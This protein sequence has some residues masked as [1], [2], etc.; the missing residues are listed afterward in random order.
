MTCNFLF[1][2][3]DKT[4][5]IVL[6]PKQHR[7]KLTTDIATLDGFTL[8]PRTTVRNLGVIFDQDLACNF[9]ILNHI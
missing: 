8:A 3:A 9:H 2:N 4:E 1:L 5:V 7:N 6:G